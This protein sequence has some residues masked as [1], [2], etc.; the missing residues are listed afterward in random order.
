MTLP[1]AHLGH[2]LWIFY[3]MPV[4]IVIVGILRSTL[5]EKRRERDEESGDD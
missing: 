3:V 1:L 2:F 4:I 5:L